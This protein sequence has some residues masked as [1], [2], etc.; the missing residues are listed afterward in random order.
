MYEYDPQWGA[1]VE[2][3]DSGVEELLNKLK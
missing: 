2:L 1:Y 3:M